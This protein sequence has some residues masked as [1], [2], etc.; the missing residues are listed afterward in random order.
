MDDGDLERLGNVCAVFAG[1]AL[2]R[3]GRESHLSSKTSYAF[4]L[5]PKERMIEVRKAVTRWT[6]RSAGSMELKQEQ[7]RILGQNKGRTT[8]DGR[9]SYLIVDDNVDASPN[10]IVGQ[11]AHVQGLIH[12]ALA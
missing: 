7:A 11:L 5:M 1:A 8:G 3:V 2:F 12:D 9:P 10:L 4:I 6:C